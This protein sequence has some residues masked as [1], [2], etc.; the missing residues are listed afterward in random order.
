VKWLCSSTGSREAVAHLVDPDIAHRVVKILVVNE[1]E[2]E[3]EQALAGSPVCLGQQ[4]QL[5]DG[6]MRVGPELG[7]GRRCIA[8][9][10]A[11]DAAENVAQVQ[12]GHVAA[13]AVAMAGDGAEVRELR[14][15]HLRAEMIQLRHVI[16]RRE[17]RVLPERDEKASFR[18]FHEAEAPGVALEIL[19]RAL[20]VV[21]RMLAHPRMIE[22]RV[23]PDEIEK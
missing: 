11:P 2:A 3:I 23:I 21:F 12:H 10:A 16:P 8:Q 19:F 6:C 13:N 22:S 7:R 9:E 18:S 5:G 20:H 14:G 17:I 4:N 1:R 15:A